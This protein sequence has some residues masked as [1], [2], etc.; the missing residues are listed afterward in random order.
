LESGVHKDHYL[1]IVAP[2]G[3]DSW[4]VQCNPCGCVE[5]YDSSDEA[6]ARARE[7][8]RL[9]RRDAEPSV[10]EADATRGFPFSFDID[11]ERFDVANADAAERLF[12]EANLLDSN[13]ARRARRKLFDKILA[14]AKAP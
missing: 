5:E 4:V 1:T 6:W 7:L 12:D 3:G 2:T 11:G 14:I 10:G 9:F 8:H 13:Y